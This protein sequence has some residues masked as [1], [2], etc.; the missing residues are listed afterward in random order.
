MDD[1]SK[2]IARVKHAQARKDGAI[3][4][5]ERN[6][7]I[8]KF[9]QAQ[10]TDPS[11]ILEILDSVGAYQARSL[12]R[13]LPNATKGEI[14]PSGGARKTGKGRAR[15][16]A[17]QR[18]AIDRVNRASQDLREL[19]ILRDDLDTAS[20]N[21]QRKRVACKIHAVEKRIAQR[22]ALDA[23]PD[24]TI[25]HARKRTHDHDRDAIRSIACPTRPDTVAIG[26]DACGARSVSPLH[27]CPV[28]PD[29][30]AE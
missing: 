30:R 8:A 16:V 15:T 1:R 5:R 25:G 26:C 13:Y 17:A 14:R 10:G 9:A 6:K 21:R 11:T 12:G 3:H 23:D 19:R 28:R 22:L 18:E 2:R 27:E 4:A 29:D 7:R 20:S 24:R